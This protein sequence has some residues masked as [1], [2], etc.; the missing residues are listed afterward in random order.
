M[1]R[2]NTDLLVIMGGSYTVPILF[3]EQ[4][5]IVLAHTIHMHIYTDTHTHRHTHTHTH[6]DLS[7]IHI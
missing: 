7:L 2:P 6:T 4:K 1:S 3:A 5:F